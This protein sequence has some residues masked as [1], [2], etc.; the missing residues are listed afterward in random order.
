MSRIA[1]PLRTATL[2]ALLFI[3]IACIVLRV[4]FPVPEKHK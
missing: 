3:W 1:K 2:L 4:M